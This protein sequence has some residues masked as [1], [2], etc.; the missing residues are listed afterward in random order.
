MM[1]EDSKAFLEKY[2]EA[3][4]NM[5]NDVVEYVR[6]ISVVKYLGKLLFI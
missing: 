3:S 6:G 5:G 4:A 1:G 2:Q